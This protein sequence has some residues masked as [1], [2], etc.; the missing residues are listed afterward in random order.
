M[1]IRLW[2]RRI[3]ILLAIVLAG[4]TAWGYWATRAPVVA[5]QRVQLSGRIDA[6]GAAGKV[7]LR[8]FQA[9]AGAGV[10]RHPLEE[11]AHFDSDSMQFDHSIDYPL[12]GGQGLIVYAWLD[13]NGDGVHCTPQARDEPAGL[14]EV[15]PFPVARAQ[16]ALALVQPCAGP[17][18]FFPAA[19]PR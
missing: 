10:L 2:L 3:G 1:R 6:N 12:N 4:L 9:W 15:L 16:V 5:T 17:E 13:R 8:V 19:A 11:I 14:V 7:H 18:Y